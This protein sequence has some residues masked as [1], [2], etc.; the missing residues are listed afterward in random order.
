MISLEERG[1]EARVYYETLCQHGGRCLDCLEKAVRGACRGAINEMEE[2]LKEANLKNQEL[3]HEIARLTR[4]EKCYDCGHSRENH[5]PGECLVW[6]NADA[7]R[8]CLCR[9]WTATEV[10][11]DIKPP[12]GRCGNILRGPHDEAACDYGNV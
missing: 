1:K 7:H 4:N 11:V 5:G 3:Q 6:V 12:C 10:R 2:E 8:K 9:A